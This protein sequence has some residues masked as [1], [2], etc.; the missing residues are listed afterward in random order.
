MRQKASRRVALPASKD[1]VNYESIWS[2]WAKE[3]P[4]KEAANRE[5]AVQRMRDCL[6]NNKTELRLRMLGLTTIPAYIPEQITTLVLD[7]NQLESLPENLHGN[8]QALFARSNELT[9]IPATLP[10]TIRQ[11]DLSINHI[12]E[13]PGRLPSAL[14]SLDFLIIKSVIYRTICLMGFSTCT[15]MITA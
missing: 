1:A 12:A 4:A 6:K 2:E 13:L 14:Q 9:S 5:K 10:D 3:A 7:H 8:I 11:M 15:F